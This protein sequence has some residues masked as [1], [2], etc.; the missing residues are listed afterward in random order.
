MLQLR[1]LPWVADPPNS[2]PFLNL[3]KACTNDLRALKR[4]LRLTMDE[5]GSFPSYC[6]AEGGASEKRL[7][8]QLL[9]F[10]IRGTADMSL[11]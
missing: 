6:P 1:A 2:E 5:S 11:S 10:D 9:I 8:P 4:T 7:L 3:A